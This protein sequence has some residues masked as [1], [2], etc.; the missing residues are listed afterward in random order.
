MN[1]SY[2]ILIHENRTH[3][4][5]AKIGTT[6]K[7]VPVINKDTEV[8]VEPIITTV[9]IHSIIEMRVF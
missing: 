6:T 1:I 4:F 8:V 3:A 2:N 5:P 9:S 7:A